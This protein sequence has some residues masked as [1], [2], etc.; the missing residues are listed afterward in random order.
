[1]LETGDPDDHMTS[2][3]RGEPCVEARLNVDMVVT[4][5]RLLHHG[6]V[7][8]QRPKMLA[9]CPGERKREIGTCDPDH[10]SQG[11]TTKPPY[12]G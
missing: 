9:K 12:V 3:R 4:R 8:A 6:D 5:P 11:T 10:A 2:P 1:M 7:G